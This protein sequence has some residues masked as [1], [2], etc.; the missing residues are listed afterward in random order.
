MKA[1]GAYLDD[2]MLI[3]ASYFKAL[4]FQYFFSSGGGNSCVSTIFMEEADC[5]GLMD[6]EAWLGCHTP[7]RRKG[8]QK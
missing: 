6:G 8:C 2:L 1:K 3:L 5:Q 4:W 7:V